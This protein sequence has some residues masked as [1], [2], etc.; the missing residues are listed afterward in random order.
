MIR[1]VI[2]DI[3]G[4]LIDSVDFHA[5]AWQRAFRQWGKEVP[6]QAVRDQ[7]GKGG[8]QL[9]PVF[10]SSDELAA[11]EEPMTEWRSEL[12]RKEYLPR[13]RAFPLVRALF[14]RLVADGRRVALASS[15]SGSELE[16][17]KAICGIEGLV[18]AEASKDDAESSK[19]EPDIFEAALAKLDHPA[20]E[21]TIVIGDTPYDI[22]AAGKA[23][24]RTVA[25]RCGG[26]P[27][28]KLRGAVAIYDDPADL[29]ARYAEWAN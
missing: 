7:I 29:M 25:V 14:E 17:F 28:E 13:I 2:F 20:F 6:F 10:W 4:T 24:L 11:V 23:G 22:E 12:F 15:A 5:E 3:D 26:F 1:T 16:E 19:P 8:D 9:L 18:H 21:E 27:D